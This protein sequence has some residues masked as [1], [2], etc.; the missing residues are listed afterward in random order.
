VADE[1]ENNQTAKEALETD[2]FPEPQLVPFKAKLWLYIIAGIALG[3]I[4]L[5]CVTVLIIIASRQ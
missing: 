5:M 1:Q 2:A 3:G 4:A